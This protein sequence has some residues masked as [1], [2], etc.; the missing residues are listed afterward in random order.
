ML[1]SH[2]SQN[3]NIDPRIGFF[4]ALAAEWD[5]Q[6]PTS[7]TA[8]QRLC[9]HADLLALEAGQDLLEV[10]CGTGKT[11]A[12]LAAQVA[13]GRVTAVDFAPEMIARA[14]AKGIDARFC[15][16]DVCQQDLGRHRFDVVLCLHSFPHFRDPGAALCNFSRALRP[17]GRVIVM[18]LA[19]SARI[20]RFHSGVAGP[21]RDDRLP[22]GDDWPVLLAQAGL[23]CLRQIDRDELFFLDAALGKGR[24]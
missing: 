13:P 23:R 8:V 18:H 24:G 2:Q 11:T 19:S 10:G 22:A 15:C 4:D 6:E 12:W 14:Q 9:E 3:R 7:R 20:N 1:N 5:W 17:G 21:V 16:L